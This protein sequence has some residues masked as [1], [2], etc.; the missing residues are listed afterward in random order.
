MSSKKLAQRALD[1]LDRVGAQLEAAATE[2]GQTD[3]AR[4]GSGRQGRQKA[5]AAAK[6]VKDAD[7]IEAEAARKVQQQLPAKLGAQ[8]SGSWTKGEDGL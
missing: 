4:G 5:R 6:R 2:R 7:A 3:A 1:V 8:C